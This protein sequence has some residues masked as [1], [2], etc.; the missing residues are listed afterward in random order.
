MKIQEW[1][2]CAGITLKIINKPINCI[3]LTKLQNSGPKQNIALVKTFK[4]LVTSGWLDKI[5]Y[6]HRK[7]Y[8]IGTYF[9]YAN[10]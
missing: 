10:Y 8:L 1:D 3:F 2:S 5:I 9:S 7:K 4:S 6:E